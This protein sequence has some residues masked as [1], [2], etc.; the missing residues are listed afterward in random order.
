MTVIMHDIV[1]SNCSHNTDFHASSQDMFPGRFIS[2]FADI[3]L[4]ACSPDLA[5]SEYCHLVYGKSK[6]YET[7]PAKTDDL[8]IQ[9]SMQGIHKDMLQYV[10]KS[11]KLQMQKYTK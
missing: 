4:S 11:F 5:V 6:A 1:W 10:M 8:R 3:T 7:C 2:H 9:E